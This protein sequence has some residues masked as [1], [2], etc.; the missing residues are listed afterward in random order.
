M[1]S[2]LWPLSL[3]EVLTLAQALPPGKPAPPLPN[4]TAQSAV[5]RGTVIN[6]T[7]GSPISGVK[8]FRERAWPWRERRV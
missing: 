1:N 6:Y 2:W 8:I 4:S 5:I 7:D 3:L